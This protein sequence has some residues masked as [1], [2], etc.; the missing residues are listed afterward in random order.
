M[1]ACN[2]TTCK[3]CYYSEEPPRSLPT[4]C[5]KYNCEA[6]K[7]D[8]TRVSKCLKLFGRCIGKQDRKQYGKVSLHL[9]A[10]LEIAACHLPFSEQNMNMADQN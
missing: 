7:N 6:V 9:C 8:A 3:A 5:E 2:V 1:S 4:G 10:E